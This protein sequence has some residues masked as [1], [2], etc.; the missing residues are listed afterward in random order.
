MPRVLDLSSNAP[1]WLDGIGY[2]A[3]HRPCLA[4]DS[5]PSG[6]PGAPV[7]SGDLSRIFAKTSHFTQSR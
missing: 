4:G 1:T 5:D 3:D 2:G 7:S 6:H